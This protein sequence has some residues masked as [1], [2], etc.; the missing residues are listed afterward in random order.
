MYYKVYQF[1]APFIRVRNQK[2]LSERG[3]AKEAGLSRMTLR[4]IEAGD[5]RVSLKSLCM[6]AQSLNRNI[7]VLLTPEECRSD[8]STYAVGIQVMRDGFES[9]KIHFMEMVDE[10]RKT[11]DPR[12]FV[13]PPPSGLDT[14]LRALLAS[15][16]C[17]LS[18][19]ASMDVPLWADR[20]HPL[21]KPWFV[22][23]IQALKPSA[24]VESRLAFRRNNIFVLD[25]FLRR[26]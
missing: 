13:L 15:M 20:P 2:R 14:K 21:E 10:F 26:A 8:L 16:V 7:Q 22:S 6:L 1:L 25:N 9:W 5:V 11:L 4:A 17:V 18:H 19:E 3:L 23:D 12:L 24:L